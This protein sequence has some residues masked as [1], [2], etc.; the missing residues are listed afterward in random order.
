MAD[1]KERVT[2]NV[3]ELALTNSVTVAALVELLE[4]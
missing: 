1:D 3:G 2:V 4:E